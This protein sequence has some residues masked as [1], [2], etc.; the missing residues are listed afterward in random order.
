[1]ASKLMAP[2]PER[3][4]DPHRDLIHAVEHAAHLLPSQGPIG[5]FI[6]HNTLHAFQSHPFE[7]AVLE[8]STLFNAQPFLSEAAYQAALASGRI[9][10][11]DIR[12]VVHQEPDA[13]LL[14][15][16]LT[17]RQL[18][19]RILTTGVRSVPSPLLPWHL[20]EGDWLQ[21]FRGDLPQESVLALTLSN[22]SPRTLWELAVR[23]TPKATP[24]EPASW[25]RPA[26]AIRASRGVDLDAV[27]HPL[28]IRLTSAYLDQGVS[29]W[30][31][32]DRDR[33]F[34]KAVAQVLSQ[35]GLP[36]PVGLTGLRR[37]F[38]T[39]ASENLSAPEVLHQAITELGIH[40][41][42][43]ADLIT[44]E[45]LA[46]PGWAGMVR[47]LEEHPELAPHVRL[48]CSLLE[49]VA[50]RLVITGVA[51]RNVL[52]GANAWRSIPPITRQTTD[53]SAQAAVFD[54]L[55]V[56]GV[57]T[58]SLRSL[59]PKSIGLL[60]QE[61]L[62]F[63]ELERRRLLH[64]A[65][66]RRHERLVL[67]PLRHHLRGSLPAHPGERLSAQ[68]IFC[69]DDREE[70]LRRAL[71]ETDPSVDTYGAAGFFGCAIDYIGIDD[72]GAVSL[73]PVVVK[74]AHAVGEAPVS[75]HDDLHERRRRLRRVWSSW[76]RSSRISSGTLF[77]GFA[78]TLLLGAL[79]LFPLVLR[80]LSP[81]AHARLIRWLN[82]RFL[83]EPRTEL[84][85]MRDDSESKEATQSLF[86]GFTTTE[87]ADRVAGV[88]GP[89]GLRTGHARLVI[90]LGH[91]STSLNNPHESAYD[92]GA[93][94]GRTGGPNAR[95]FA[96]MA[97]HPEVRSK[98]ADRGIRIPDDTWFIGG[99]HDTCSDD[100]D[101][102][103]LENL[104]LSHRGDL[105]R[106][107]ETL[108]RAR[109]L[110]ALERT[111][112]FQAAHGISEPAT[113]LRHVQ[114]RSEHL[115]EPRPEYGH[116]TNAVAFVGRRETTRGLFLDRRAFLI[117]YDKDVDPEGR[118]L[119]A[120][121]GAVVPVCG[122]INLEYYFSTVD[123]E[124]YGCGTKLPHNVTGL[125]GVMNGMQGDL[126][127]GLTWQ[128]VE[129]HEPVRILFIVENTPER[130]LATFRANPLLWELLENRWIR[131]A[132]VD[133]ASGEI[134][135][136][137][138][139]GRFE[140]V[141]GSEVDLPIVRSSSEYHLN[142]MDHLPIVRIQPRE[143]Q[144]A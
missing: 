67:L 22:D 98:L 101:L 30:P 12:H 19:E 7:S 102:F 33:G 99:Y 71:E 29:Y 124:R 37:R 65:Y 42:D 9:L 51:T 50:V 110:S 119:A 107:R 75:G 97:N 41:G 14:P 3:G 47:Q 43:S 49:F 74:P 133:A 53:L 77:R 114:G 95:L 84:R 13:V 34:L 28:L 130:A 129:I 38:L 127:T 10:A 82:A 72:A 78:S 123:N 81:L 132:T 144:C 15:G 39:L 73:C 69:I 87:M 54:A 23:W 94:G 142:R 18:H 36:D 92:C 58:E 138:G 76:T 100:I 105:A 59:P 89:A 21:R 109:A 31:M 83:P 96:R 118:S 46:L 134:R 88:L 115:G 24:A 44:A 111:R 141:D 62:S 136:Y 140:A 131:L 125:L 56:L 63:G 121:L 143:P 112:R 80:I 55:Q 106:V 5:V 64:L 104:P 11:E 40:P 32:P 135:M 26:E 128:M 48:R 17:R 45:L 126:R 113:A 90:V 20:E 8:A 16:G 6:H 4:T 35:P 2:A 70:S 66:E 103:D 117:S 139:E 86:Q 108:D 1:M 85:F 93:C 120:I 91:G 60:V 52:G 79:S 27:V 57:G 25:R 68:F 122:G 137:R 116:S 61:I